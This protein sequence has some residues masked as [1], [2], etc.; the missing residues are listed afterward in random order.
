LQRLRD[1]KESRLSSTQSQ[2]PTRKADK[3]AGHGTVLLV[4]KLVFASSTCH[5][6]GDCDRQTESLS[7]VAILASATQMASAARHKFTQANALA[8]EAEQGT[9]DSVHLPLGR[10]GACL[11]CF[12]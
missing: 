2:T 12:H 7:Y 6:G 4:S 9:P 11:P 3:P 10:L 1:V 5:G 8:I